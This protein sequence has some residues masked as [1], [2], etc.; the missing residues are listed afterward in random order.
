MS[1]I[2]YKYVPFDA[3][4]RIIETTTLGFS[5]SKDFNDPFD[6]PSYPPEQ[7]DDPLG[8]I[9]ERLR[10]MAKENT[11]ADNTGIL[12]LTR[13]PFNPLMWAHYADKHRGMVIGID[14]EAAGLAKEAQN[15]IPVQYGSVIYVSRRP[16]QPFIDK[17]TTGL[18]VGATHNFPRDHYEK[19]QR[20]F[21][22]KPLCWCYEEEVRVVKCLKDIPKEGG[23]T[24]SGIFQTVDVDERSLHLLTIPAEA[25]R[26]VYL[27]FGLDDQKAEEFYFWC[28]EHHTDLSVFECFLMPDNYTVGANKY[29]TINGQRL[30]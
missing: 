30:E 5:Q 17:P 7:A 29:V 27:G 26:E 2:L 19:L 25:L 18:A 16:D 28:Q 24:P 4:R 10:I 20:L 1:M 12:S 6:A 23:E 22:H 9:F 3:G 14:V 8:N 15:L 11:W 13:T 21:L